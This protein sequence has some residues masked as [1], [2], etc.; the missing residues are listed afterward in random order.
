M[1]EF[2]QAQ[3][4][5]QTALKLYIDKISGDI[6][7]PNLI[8]KL[9][10][11]QIAFLNIM[12]SW[13]GLHWVIP[14][15]MINDYVT[16]YAHQ[17]E[18]LTTKLGEL[19]S[20]A[21]LPYL[22]IP[23]FAPT[24]VS[25][26]PAEVNSGFTLFPEAPGNYFTSSFSPLQSELPTPVITSFSGVFF[27]PRAT[28]PTAPPLPVN[29]LPDIQ[30][31]SSLSSSTIAPTLSGKRSH[32]RIAEAK[33]VGDLHIKMKGIG[34]TPSERKELR[35]KR[36]RLSAFESRERQKESIQR[37]EQQSKQLQMEEQVLREEL[38]EDFNQFSSLLSLLKQNPSSELLQLAIAQLETRIETLNTIL[39][40]DT[41]GVNPPF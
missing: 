26:A 5:L 6:Q 14:S 17:K 13:E 16:T 11:D 18:L 33:R 20:E 37:L 39:T 12:I 21:Y 32:Q 24:P 3:L 7:E 41:P 15:N 9:T 1:L 2:Y 27:S 34:L 40:P 22:I 4:A 10:A 30:L 25:I 19:L 35:L 23:N 28:C 31:E 38:H 8:Q 36:N 29:S